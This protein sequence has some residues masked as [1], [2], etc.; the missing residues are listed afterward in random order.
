VPYFGLAL[1]LVALM[2]SGAYSFRAF[3]LQA[4]SFWIHVHAA[5][6]VALRRPGTFKVTPKRGAAGAQPRT[7]A[8]GLAVIAVLLAASVYG[9]MRERDPSTL[10]NIAFALVHVTIL[11]FGVAPALRRAPARAAPA[12]AAVPLRRVA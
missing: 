2:G 5:V 6:A 8:P 11:G 10:N 9:L 7:V 12:T 1:Y 4:A 3:A